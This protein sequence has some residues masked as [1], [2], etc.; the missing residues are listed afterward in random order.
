MKRKLIENNQEKRRFGSIRQKSGNCFEAQ[1]R[2][3]GVRKSFTARTYEAAATKLDKIELE[4][5]QD[6]HHADSSMPL[7][8]WLTHWLDVYILPTTAISTYSQYSNYCNNHVIPKL[9]SLPLRKVTVDTVQKFFN[10]KAVSGRLD[11]KEGGLSLKTLRNLRSILSEAFVQAIADSKMSYNPISGLRLAKQPAPRMRV[12][13]KAEQ[14]AVEKTA[15]ASTKTNALGIVIDLNLGLRLG[16]LLGLQWNSVYL[17]VPTP[18]IDVKRQLVRQYNANKK[19][20][21]TTIIRGGEKTN[22]VLKEVLKSAASYRRLYLPNF[23]ADH[24]RKIKDWQDD[25][26]REFGNGYNTLG[27][28]FCSELGD[29]FD[30]RTYTD[31]FYRIVKAAGVNNANFHCMRHTFASRLAERKVD[32]ATIAKLL[33]HESP[34]FTLDRYVHSSD[35]QILEVAGSFDRN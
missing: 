33:G 24:F 12:L 32:P 23:V 35:D 20:S 28:V 26:G 22:L 27:F 3:D 9:G 11:G 34:S 29:V 17:D 31:I 7:R 25:M 18:Y 5:Q 19:E 4:I 30:P 10:E 15:E 14:D 2:H 21:G 8:D 16:E 13:T 6:S 1:Y